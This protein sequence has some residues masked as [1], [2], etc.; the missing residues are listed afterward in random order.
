MF[1]VYWTNKILLTLLGASTGLVK[2]F[3]M[4]KEMELF[5]NA[6]FSNTL[7]IVFGIVQVA[8]TALIWFPATLKIGA[9][10]LALTFL[11]ATL[12]VFKN[13]MMP[14]GIISLLFIAMAAFVAFPP[15]K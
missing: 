5:R 6:G 4:E 9:G 8:A 3:G 15:A 10:T 11:I 14:F 7:T 12:V 1:Y 13:G 2:I